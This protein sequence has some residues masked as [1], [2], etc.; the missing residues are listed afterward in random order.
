LQAALTNALADSDNAKLAV[1]GAA[2]DLDTAKAEAAQ[3]PTDQG[4]QSSVQIARKALDD[5]TQSL[6]DKQKA[7]ETAQKAVKGADPSSS[8][9]DAT[10]AITPLSIEKISR[11]N[12]VTTTDAIM[13]R[14]VVTQL[15]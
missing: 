14:E 2:Q 5:A 8:D 12:Q 1:D 11:G 10:P 15:R 13:R 7:V 3:D 9:S 4:K 6:S